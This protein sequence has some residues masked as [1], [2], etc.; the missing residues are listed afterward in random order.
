MWPQ[1]SKAKEKVEECLEQVQ[2]SDLEV[3]SLTAK[4]DRRTRLF[5]EERKLY[6]KEFLMLKELVRRAGLLDDNSGLLKSFEG[7]F[8]AVS[9]SRRHLRDNLTTARFVS[10]VFVRHGCEY[11][12]AANG[13]GT[14]VVAWWVEKVKEMQ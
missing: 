11:G 6:Y 10:M 5:D 8:L 13:A 3:D 4:L 12:G 9:H 14:E 2:R 1:L 7:P